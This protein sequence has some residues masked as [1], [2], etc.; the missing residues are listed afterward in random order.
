MMV[1]GFFLMPYV[2]HTIGDQSYGTWVFLNAVAGYTGLL[3]LGFGETISK[4]VSQHYARQEW[5]RLNAVVSGICAAYSVS[6]GIAIVG[7]VVFAAVAPWMGDWEGQSIVEVQG[8]IV[9]LGLSAALSIIGSVNGGVLYGIQRFDLERGILIAGTLTKLGLTLFFLSGQYSLMTLALVFLVHTA[10]EQGL[11]FVV[12]RRLVPTLRIRR[13]YIKW[14]VVKDSYGFAALSGVGL[15]ASKLIYDTDFIVIG[16]ALGN[17]AIVPYAIGSRLCAMIRQPIMQVGEV[18]L[19]RASELNA[20]A[21]GDILRSLVCRGMGIAFLMSAGLFIG[22]CYFGSAMIEVWM[23]EGYSQSQLV[24]LV[25]IGAQI[26]AA[27]SGILHMVLVGIGDVRVPS[28]LRLAQAVLNLGLSLLLVKPFGVVGVALGTM[29]PILIIDLAVL[30]PYGV[31]RLEMSAGHFLKRSVAPHLLPLAA[32][33]AY[34]DRV[35]RMAWE[36]GWP[37]ILAVTAGGGAVL[38]LTAA[39]VWLVTERRSVK[40]ALPSGAAVPAHQSV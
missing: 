32:L 2:I 25:L 31:R 39:G 19:P 13:R 9:V 35:S 8:V 40:S 36:P 23:G 22:G 16:F 10:L 28:L 34:S 3:Y 12:A 4:Y 21:D 7:A 14:S 17:A 1:I 38:V 11:Y 18:F 27:P 24:F 26:A 29:I 30:I 6:G 33:W 5:D 15:V 20:R 37:T